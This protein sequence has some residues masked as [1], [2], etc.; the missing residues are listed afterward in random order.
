MRVRDDDTLNVTER[1]RRRYEAMRSQAME[2][3]PFDIEAD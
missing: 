2:M 1:A 3:R